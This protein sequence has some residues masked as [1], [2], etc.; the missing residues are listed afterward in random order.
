MPI[1]EAN[2]VWRYSDNTSSQGFSTVSTGIT[3]L[4]KQVAS[5]PVVSGALHGLFDVVTGDES[6]A[7]K[8]EYRCIFIHNTHA[9]LT[10]Q[11]P[12]LWITDSGA[13]GGAEVYISLSAS[14]VKASGLATLQAENVADETDSTTKLS[15]LSFVKTCNSKATGLA[16]SDLPPNYVQGI[17]IKRVIAPSTSAVSADGV[18][19]KIEGDTAA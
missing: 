7:G 2:L 13:A 3:S 11:T 4:G 17:W 19:L 5:G 10:L 8:T 16:L 15:G 18:G 9:T 1:V 14:G 6:S 12:K